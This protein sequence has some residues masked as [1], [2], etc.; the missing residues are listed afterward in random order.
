MEEIVIRP[1]FK[2]IKAGYVIVALCLV[3]AVVAHLQFFP[4]G[5]PWLPAIAALLF[6]FPIERH[7]RRQFTKTIIAGDKLRYSTGAVS[8]ST[9]TIQLSKIQ[10]VRVDQSLW[11]RISGIGDVS[12][13][14]AGETSRLTL[15][16]I[17]G[18]QAVADE[19]IEAAQKGS[20]TRD[21]V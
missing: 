3:G 4:Q 2:F 18:P 1:S 13:E 21:K 7:M 17:D 12:I 14:T 15:E 16:N 8:K 10:D 11:Q 20:A 6:I 5:I 19:I 9:R